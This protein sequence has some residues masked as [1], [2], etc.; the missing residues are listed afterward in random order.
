MS[1][2]F[3]GTM[4]LR[5]RIILMASMWISMTLLM[6]ASSGARGNAATKMVVKLYWI[7][8]E[9]ETPGTGM[10][11]LQRGHPPLPGFVLL[12]GLDQRALQG[13]KGE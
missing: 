6:R 9:G 12:C 13:L 11:P 2:A 3:L 4:R 10:K 7:T 5:S 1:L 8:V